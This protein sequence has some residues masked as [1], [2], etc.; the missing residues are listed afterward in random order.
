MPRTKRRTCVRLCSTPRLRSRRRGSAP[1]PRHTASR[2][3]TAQTATR[4]RRGAKQG[5]GRPVAAQAQ[6]V[7]EA[8]ER[9]RSVRQWDSS[10]HRRAATAAEGASRTRFRTR[11]RTRSP[12]AVLCVAA[13]LF[14]RRSR[15]CDRTSPTRA[16]HA[17]VPP[18]HRPL[19]RQC[20]V[21]DSPSPSTSLRARRRRC[22]RRPPPSHPT[23]QAV[24]RRQSPS[25]RRSSIAEAVFRG[26][27]TESI[28]DAA[29]APPSLQTAPSSFPPSSPG[30][31][32]TPIPPI[33]TTQLD[34]RGRS[35]IA[36]CSVGDS[37][38]PSTTLR[39]RHRRYKRRPPPSH[40]L[41]SST[42]P[43]RSWSLSNLTTRAFER[44]HIINLAMTSYFW[45]VNKV[46][47]PRLGSVMKTVRT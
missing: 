20:S 40:P 32:K 5:R 25:R 1:S 7:V 23:P 38:S 9:C 35:S 3:T 46:T 29:R 28:H 43:S 2:F 11:F 8:V 39:A 22:K 42:S 21:G 14:R 33:K 34:R 18:P 16:R 37:P 10:P 4:S 19:Q 27:F 30:G 12:H 41:L 13:R 15:S 47:P 6:A 36:Q 24:I 45:C 26:R 17:A 31:D 44:V